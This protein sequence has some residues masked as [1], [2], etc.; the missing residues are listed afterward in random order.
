MKNVLLVGLGRFG[1][2]VAK[3]LSEMDHEV[4]AVD[5]NEERVNDALPYVTDARIGDCT[6]AEFLKSLDVPRFDLCVVAIGDDFQSSLEITSLLKDFGAKKVVSRAC[7]DVQGKFLLRNGADNI[8]YPERQLAY[9]TAIRYASDNL[10]DYIEL[11]DE[12]GIFEV[13]PPAAWIG[14]TV[15]EIDIRKRFGVNILAFKKDG[16]TLL[17]VNCN[18]VVEEGAHMLVLGEYKDVRKCFKL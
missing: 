8:V 2:N 15:G 13:A 3:K 11:G 12:S 16:K 6:R 7:N 18:S 9:W 17:S 5:E 1:L 10:S 14:K 4:L